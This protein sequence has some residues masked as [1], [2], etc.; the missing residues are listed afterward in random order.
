[1]SPGACNDLRPATDDCVSTCA[2]ATSTPSNPASACRAYCSAVG[3]R[4]TRC[5]PSGT[6]F[7]SSATD[8]TAQATARAL[9]AFRRSHDRLMDDAARAQQAAALVA[10]QVSAL[11]G[12]MKSTDFGAML[13]CVVAAEHA[14][15]NAAAIIRVCAEEAVPRSREH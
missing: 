7:A 4:E 1:M 10:D 15:H 9:T 2:S 8:A 6:T 3:M 13:P 5:E 12:H 11:R 14:A